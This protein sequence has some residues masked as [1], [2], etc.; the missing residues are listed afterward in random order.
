MGK[1]RSGRVHRPVLVVASALRDAGWS[2]AF[3]DTGVRSMVEEASFP[4][5]DQDTTDLRRLDGRRVPDFLAIANV[6]QMLAVSAEFHRAELVRRQLDA[7]LATMTPSRP[8]LVVID[9]SR[10]RPSPP[11]SWGS[12]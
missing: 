1:R 12:R 11:P 2:V 3:A 8:D 4:V 9:L 7:D 6:D 10:Q 5:I